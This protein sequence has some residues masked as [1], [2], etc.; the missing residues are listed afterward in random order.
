VKILDKLEGSITKIDHYGTEM[1]SLIVYVTDKGN[2]I[3]YT[4]QIQT[5]IDFNLCDN[6]LIDW[7]LDL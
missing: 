7:L 2:I 1:Q 6:N 5:R 4:K 3:H